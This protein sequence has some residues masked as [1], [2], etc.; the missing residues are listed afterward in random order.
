MLPPAPGNAP[1]SVVFVSRHGLPPPPLASHDGFAVGK[2]PLPLKSTMRRRVGVAVTR[3]IIASAFVLAAHPCG[4]RRG[5]RAG[6]IA[7]PFLRPE[8]RGFLSR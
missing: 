6:C 4:C 3:D 2:R 1:S 8:R 5:A 7:E